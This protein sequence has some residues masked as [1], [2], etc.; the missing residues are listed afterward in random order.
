MKNITNSNRLF[1]EGLIII[2]LIII[3][4]T[5]NLYSALYTENGVSSMFYKHLIFI[6]IGTI[7]VLLIQIVNNSYIENTAREAFIFCVLLLVLVLIAGKRVYG[8]KRWL[9]T[10]SF[11]F[12]PSELIKLV[13]IF[14]LAKFYRYMPL[15]DGGYKLHHLILPFTIVMI[16]TLLIAKQ[17]DLGTAL[18]LFF[19]AFFMVLLLGI[20]RKLILTV[21]G[22]VLLLSPIFWHFLKDYQKRRVYAFLS[23]ESDP[24]GSGY[25]TIQANIAVGTGG[26]WG[27]GYLKGVQSKLGFIPEKHTDFAFSVFAEEW[28]FIGVLI[29]IILNLLLIHW[30]Y[31]V[32]KNIKDRFVFLT[33][34]GIIIFFSLH[35]IVNLAMV[36]GLF[37]VVGVPLPLFSY[38]GTALIVHL[39]ALGFILKLSRTS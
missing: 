16:P 33:G 32:V 24:L 38:G 37:P 12:Q 8:A 34:A 3:I 36:C 7:S 13:T 30:M 21:F 2:L 14:Y 17:P 26:F 35:F 23:P 6:F 5:V 11:S 18:I 39:T 28:G 27:K 20:N 19:T 4:G 31:K 10:A 9:G 1:Y 15:C 29:Y 22:L 25:H